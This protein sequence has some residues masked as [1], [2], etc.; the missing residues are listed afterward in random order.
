MINNMDPIHSDEILR[1]EYLEPPGMSPSALHVPA[2]RSGD[3]VRERRGTSPDA[4]LRLACYFGA[5]AQSWMNLQISY[6]RTTG[7]D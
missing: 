2:T 1:E 6:M 5:D 3:I 7:E 4:R